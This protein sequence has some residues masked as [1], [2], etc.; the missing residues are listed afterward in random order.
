[1]HSSNPNFFLVTFTKLKNHSF[2]V[3][4][5]KH[6]LIF[7]SSDTSLI[8][9]SP[10]SLHL[11]I[12][13]KYLQPWTTSA[14]VKLYHVL[15]FSFLPNPV[16]ISNHMD[17]WLVCFMGFEEVNHF[18]FLGQGWSYWQSVGFCHLV[19]FCLLLFQRG[20]IEFFFLS[21]TLVVLDVLVEALL[22]LNDPL[23]LT[24]S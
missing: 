8:L 20:V 23:L 11:L 5:F 18:Q 16:H 24:A 2:K 22:T 15:I 6:F 21:L 10:C 3:F 12:V 14:I 13:L 7:L 17:E 1:M 9:L 4:M 19:K